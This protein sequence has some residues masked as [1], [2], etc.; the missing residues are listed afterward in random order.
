[1][2]DSPQERLD[3]Y[4]A[5]AQE[6]VIP[7]APTPAPSSPQ[8]GYIQS[9]AEDFPKNLVGFG[10]AGLSLGTGL[11]S[12]L[13]SAF[14]GSMAL[15]DALARGAAGNENPTL[16]ARKIV[17][18]GSTPVYSPR[19]QAGQDM[20]SMLG[21]VTGLNKLDELTT[22]AANTAQDQQLE[23]KALVEAMTGNQL[24]RPSAL[25]P[26]L[27]K[28]APDL[29]AALLGGR[30]SVKAV[31]DQ[32][33]V[34]GQAQDIG[35]DMS[36][37]YPEQAGQ[38]VQ[39]GKDFGADQP[40]SAGMADVGQRVAELNK[41]ESKR[42]GPM[43]DEARS[44]GAEISTDAAPSLTL[45]ID[46]IVDTYPGIEGAFPA[47]ADEIR[48]LDIRLFPPTGAPNAAKIDIN[49]MFEIR[50]KINK[51][52]PR[53]FGTPEYAALA[54][55]KQSIDTFLNDA[56]TND[57]VQGNTQA[58]SKWNDAIGQ[59]AE[60]KDLYDAEGALVKLRQDGATA[61]QVK[62]YIF[63]ASSMTALPV[64]ETMVS[65]LKQILGPDSVEFQTL[66]KS[67]LS[68]IMLPV[69]QRNPDFQRFVDN[70]D[71]FIRNNPDMAKE[72]FTPEIMTQLESY[73]DFAG[74]VGRTMPAEQAALANPFRAIPV[75][76]AGNE[77]AR[78]SLLL[79]SMQ[80]FLEAIHPNP[81]NAR[82]V[83]LMEEM[84]GYDSRAAMFPKGAVVAPA[85][86][87]GQ[88]RANDPGEPN[89]QLQQMFD[90]IT[91]E[92]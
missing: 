17:E 34:E 71:K 83:Q 76:G 6:P 92:N 61:N 32:R 21:D 68:E 69:F 51:N 54:E 48:G 29:G 37:P 46:K 26:S 63:G 9:V 8:R 67:A 19:T 59:W 70:Y 3:R 30:G 87:E 84:L 73:R 80:K 72:L 38:I 74:A 31:R 2:A 64:A 82:K 12:G 86:L 52:L 18:M 15:V 4:R 88:R 44:L 53:D 11:V 28:V 16:N 23:N 79:S 40:P 50:G 66:R 58:I 33:R 45:A 57:L 65:H 78:N 36:A 89:P 81:G 75:M 13:S 55:T 90:G 60:F 56:L 10:E 41:A 47:I 20:L 85:A 43:F 24:D 27:I 14:G 7:D 35:L 1:M 22:N 25:L 49:R 39:K 91:G 42:I 77:L 62:K 5:E